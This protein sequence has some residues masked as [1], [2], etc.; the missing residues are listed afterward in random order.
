ME[1][2]MKE[3]K[4]ILIE[5]MP[6]IKYIATE[7]GYKNKKVKKATNLNELNAMKEKMEKDPEFLAALVRHLVLIKHN[8]YS[9]I[10]YSYYFRK[11]R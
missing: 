9:Y 5:M 2:D 10:T 1:V 8:Q 11:R 7:L 4:A 6:L 3:Q